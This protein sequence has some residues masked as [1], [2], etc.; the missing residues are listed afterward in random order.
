MQMGDRLVVLRQGRIS[1]AGRPE[2]VYRTPGSRYVADFM[3]VGNLFAGRVR[4]VAGG[5]AVTTPLGELTVD[6]GRHPADTEVTALIRP[7]HVRVATVVGDGAEG[8]V[9]ARMFLGATVQLVIDVDG[10]IV[11]AWIGDDERLDVG[12]RVW[13]SCRDHVV[14]KGDEP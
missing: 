4:A 3:G 14:V 11:K 8:T 1:Q 9:V 12:S 2:D 5:H 7:Q 6:G 10:Q 13:V